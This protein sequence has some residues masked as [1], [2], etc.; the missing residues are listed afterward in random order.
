MKQDGDGLAHPKYKRP[1]SFHQP[2]YLSKGETSA[3]T[4]SEHGLYYAHT[5]TESPSRLHQLVSL[6]EG[7]Q[8]NERVERDGQSQLR[9]DH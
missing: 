2:T 8:D 1:D 4:V 7:Q 9:R 5:D 3:L 6:V